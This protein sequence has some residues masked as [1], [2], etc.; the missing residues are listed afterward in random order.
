MALYSESFRKRMVE[1]LTG[2]H[3]K[4][5]TALAM[6]VG[7]S[8][9]TLSRWLK[10]A[11]TGGQT[12]SGSDDP[13]DDPPPTKRPQD[14]TA[15][16]KWALVT[17][18]AVVSQGELGALLRRKGSTRRSSSSGGRRRWRGCSRDTGDAIFSDRYIVRRHNARG[19]P[20]TFGNVPY[21][22]SAWEQGCEV[23]RVPWRSGRRC[24]L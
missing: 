12:M 23:L 8:Q 5:A 17:E 1:K 7:M 15:E 19:W 20:V 14:W 16:E 24:N 22:R 10:G 13:K 3:A 9:A 2:P 18:A 21:F 6:E 11:G 4:S